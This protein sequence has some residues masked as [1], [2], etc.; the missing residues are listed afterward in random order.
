MVSFADFDSA[1]LWD[2]VRLSVLAVTVDSLG[3]AVQFAVGEI[4]LESCRDGSLAAC[5]GA[6]DTRSKN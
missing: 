1:Q 3:F 5:T 2:D 4:L 6:L